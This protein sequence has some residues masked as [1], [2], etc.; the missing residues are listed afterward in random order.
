MS[1]REQNT[2]SGRP[3][4]VLRCDEWE[5]L[6][7]DALDGTLSAADAAAFDRH[8]AECALCAQMLKETQQGKAW[9]EY[10]A[11]EPEPPADLFKKILARTSGAASGEEAG[12]VPGV[13]LPVRA[14][15][16]RPAWHR[17]LPTV[18]QVARQAFEPRLMMTA[19]MAFFSIALTLNLTGV[20]LNDLRASDFKPSSI[21]RTASQAKTR[22]VQY[23]DNLRV[24]YELES[25]V[26]DLQRSSDDNGSSTTPAPQNDP[27]SGQ[28]PGDPNKPANQKQDQKQPKPNPGS[29][30]RETPSAGVQ[31]VDLVPP[32]ALP[33][34]A[35]KP[36]VVFIPSV[37]L[38][39]G[40]V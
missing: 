14:V 18:R 25:R 32:Q 23:T 20:R 40:L 12:V 36:F 11:A 30:R 4:R 3:G 9:I 13:P 28:Q 39:G 26:R 8:Q 16:P 19:A 27:S 6:I 31:L 1:E 38:E 5:N 35:S 34:F 15:P 2:P 21:M 33:P 29:S 22:V 24:V 17:V 7:A 37:K 10:L